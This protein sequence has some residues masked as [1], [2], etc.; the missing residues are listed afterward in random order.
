MSRNFNIA[1]CDSTII[2]LSTEMK[3]TYPLYY[4][5]LLLAAH[6]RAFTTIIITLAH[7]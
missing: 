5:W 7:K 1:S 2:K 3:G 6:V 4:F